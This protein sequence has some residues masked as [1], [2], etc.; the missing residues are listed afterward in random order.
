M[1]PDEMRRAIAEACGFRWIR[2]RQ[3]IVTGDSL[4]GQRVLTKMSVYV[5]SWTEASEGDRILGWDVPDYPNDLTAIQ[6]A[7][8]GRFKTAKD[9]R[10]FQEYLETAAYH[11]DECEVWQLTALDWCEAY[12]KTVGKL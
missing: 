5:C 3:S 1:T 10:I 2:A 7:A 9:I 6:E 12:L 4:T 8:L 11:S